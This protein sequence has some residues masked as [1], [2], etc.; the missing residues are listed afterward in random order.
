[1][2]SSISELSIVTARKNSAARISPPLPLVDHLHE[3]AEQIE[4]VMRSRRRL[5]VVR[6]GEH[7][8]A[9]VA[10]AFE[11]LV[12]EIDVRVLDVVLAERLGIDGEAVVLRGDLDAARAQVLHRMIAAAVPE[13]ELVRL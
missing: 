3:I 5:G 12:I 9:A 7:G 13:L 1:M 11:R 10:E 2:R 8:L 4:R 6:H